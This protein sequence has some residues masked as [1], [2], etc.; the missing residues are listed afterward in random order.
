MRTLSIM[1]VAPTSIPRILWGSFLQS[2][3]AIGAQMSP[4]AIKPRTISQLK[5]SGPMRMRKVMVMA[6]VTKNSAK[7]TE[8]M[9]LFGL[10]LLAMRV[11]V[12]IGPQP[13]LPKQGLGN[14]GLLHC[15][16]W[17]GL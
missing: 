13:P 4:P 2:Q 7:L 14:R 11:V 1:T 15:L 9:A 10:T 12:A 3:A 16:K 17:L 5:F 8:P 6:V